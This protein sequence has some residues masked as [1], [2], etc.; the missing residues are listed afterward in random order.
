[1]S[2][3]SLALYPLPSATLQWESIGFLFLAERLA[4]EGDGEGRGRGT[5]AFGPGRQIN[6]FKRPF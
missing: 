1:M 2:K 4:T 6:R 5:M 3:Q